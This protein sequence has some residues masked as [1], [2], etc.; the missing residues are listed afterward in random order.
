MQRFMKDSTD[1]QTIFL[2]K[3]Q[4]LH[5]ISSLW[6]EMPQLFYVKPKTNKS[7]ALWLANCTPGFA[8]LCRKNSSIPKTKPFK[9]WLIQISAPD[10]QLYNKFFPFRFILDP[11]PS[12]GSIANIYCWTVSMIKEK[13]LHYR[14]GS[15]DNIEPLKVLAKAMKF[16]KNK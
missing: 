2:S 10:F 12:P 11:S 7:E 1:I 16:W 3:Y 8:L 9:F 6:K 15:I 13:M 14:S 5:L 4:Y